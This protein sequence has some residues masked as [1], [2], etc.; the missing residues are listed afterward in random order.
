[1]LALRLLERA[2]DVGYPL[3]SGLPAQ[4]RLHARGIGLRVRDLEL[5]HAGLELSAQRLHRFGAR[6][7]VVA[8]GLGL[9]EAPLEFGL[10][11]KDRRPLWV[12]SW[13]AAS[14]SARRC[15]AASRSASSCPV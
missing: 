1:M 5:L 7:R 9:G 15:S 11:R 4:H 13:S 14:T 3:L 2:L 12:T 10:L 6:V 8:G